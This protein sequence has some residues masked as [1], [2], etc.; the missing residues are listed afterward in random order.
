MASRPSR[1]HSLAREGLVVLAL[2]AVEVVLIVFLA[3][4]QIDHVVGVLEVLAGGVTALCGVGVG[5][6]A[7]RDAMT[8]GLTSSAADVALEARK[9]DAAAKAVA[10]VPAEVVVV[11][12]EP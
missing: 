3:P 2:L 8:G 10:P 6:M 7:A 9:V 1:T 5:G 12:E 11:Q 4:D